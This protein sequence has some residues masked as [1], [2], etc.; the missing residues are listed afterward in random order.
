MSSGTG[1][2]DIRFGPDPSA[3]SGAAHDGRPRPGTSTSTSGVQWRKIT[4]PGDSSF[5]KLND[6]KPGTAYKATLTPESN[7]DYVKPLSVSFTTLSG[8]RGAR[9]RTREE[10]CH[11]F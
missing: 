11:R 10:V 1:Y 4:R 7:L 5:A 3:G 2:Y 9:G 8:E 6:L